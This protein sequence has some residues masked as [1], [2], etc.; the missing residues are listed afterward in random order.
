[1]IYG[2]RVL[3]DGYS[4]LHRAI[5]GMARG[6]I[7]EWRFEWKKMKNNPEIPRALKTIII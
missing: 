5:A 2:V 6:N 7:I 3:P 1:M 4:E